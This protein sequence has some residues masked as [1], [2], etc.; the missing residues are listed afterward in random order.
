MDRKIMFIFL[1]VLLVVVLLVV[2]NAI[3]K[4]EQEETPKVNVKEDAIQDVK[5]EGKTVF[6][7]EKR[8]EDEEDFEEEIITGPLLN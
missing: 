3:I 2:A 8:E 7:L 5:E 4:T 1:A 6:I